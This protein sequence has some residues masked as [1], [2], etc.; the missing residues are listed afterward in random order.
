MRRGI[1]F[2]N[3]IHL[4]NYLTCLDVNNLFYI[5]KRLPL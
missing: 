5:G 4:L 2:H 1:Y 3:V